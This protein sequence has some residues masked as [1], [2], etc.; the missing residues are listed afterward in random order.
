M[1]NF[2]SYFNNNAASYNYLI[3][4]LGSLFLLWGF[5]DLF[6]YSCTYLTRKIYSEKEDIKQQ[7]IIILGMNDDTIDKSPSHNNNETLA[8]SEITLSLKGP[9][10]DINNIIP[11]QNNNQCFDD[12]HSSLAS[13]SYDY[14]FAGG[15]T[16][17]TTRD[18]CDKM[19]NN[20][21]WRCLTAKDLIDFRNYRLSST[22]TNNS[23]LKYNQSPRTKILNNKQK[24]LNLFKLSHR[25]R[26]LF[27]IFAMADIAFEFCTTNISSTGNIFFL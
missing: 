12:F 3:F 16:Q 19:S 5:M 8:D 22:N 23:S 4:L 24:Q 25:F 26:G 11:N 6:I 9:N 7:Q 17:Y 14:N 21:C 10:N 20:K 1:G 27:I 13:T 15:S 2:L 18:C